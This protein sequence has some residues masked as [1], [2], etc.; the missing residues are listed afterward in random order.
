MILGL[1][2]PVMKPGWPRVDW[3]R[4]RQAPRVTLTRTAAPI[5]GYP[6]AMLARGEPYQNAVVLHGVMIVTAPV[7]G[8]R[9]PG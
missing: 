4:T 3:G 1:N 7:I 2:R 5:I 9:T 6:G 8:N